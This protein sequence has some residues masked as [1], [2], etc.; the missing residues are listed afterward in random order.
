VR[1]VELPAQPLHRSLW[2]WLKR[3]AGRTPQAEDQT[4]R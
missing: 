3:K 4:N 2:R 1:D